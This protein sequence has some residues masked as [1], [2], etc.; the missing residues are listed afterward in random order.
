MAANAQDVVANCCILVGL[1]SFV[2]AVLRSTLGYIVNDTVKF[3]VRIS[4]ED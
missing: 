1:H 4:M 2:R 3:N